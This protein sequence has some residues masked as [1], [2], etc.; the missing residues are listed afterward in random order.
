MYFWSRNFAPGCFPRILTPPIN[1]CTSTFTP[2]PPAPPPYSE[3]LILGAQPR[4]GARIT[5]TRAHNAHTTPQRLRPLWVH[6]WAMGPSDAALTRCRGTRRRY[7]PQA[8]RKNHKIKRPESAGPNAAQI[9]GYGKQESARLAAASKQGLGTAR[10]GGRMQAKGK[11]HIRGFIRGGPGGPTGPDRQQ[12]RSSAR[13]RHGAQEEEA[14]ARLGA[15]GRGGLR[16]P[17]RRA[18]SARR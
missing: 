2:F 6:G 16:A 4:L 18:T 7:V 14:A 9:R 8:T 17:A 13:A 1:F 10:R 11:G 15:G 5:R 12:Q 3:F